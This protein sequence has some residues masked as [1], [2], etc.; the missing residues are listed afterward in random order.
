MRVYGILRVTQ[1]LMAEDWQRL[2]TRGLRQARKL[3]HSRYN[4]IGN[5]GHGLRQKQS[6]MFE[7]RD[8]RVVDFRGGVD[9]ISRDRG[10][11]ELLTGQDRRRVQ[12][13]GK[14]SEE[15]EEGE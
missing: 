3:L 7:C 10:M 15:E 9:R 8:D 13:G 12:R 6:G 11:C 4:H 2:E 1:L 14:D 5:W